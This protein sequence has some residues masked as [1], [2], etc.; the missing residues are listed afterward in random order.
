M[1]AFAG[2]RQPRA[3]PQP[4][5]VGQ[6]SRASTHLLVGRGRTSELCSGCSPKRARISGAT[7]MLLFKQFL[8]IKSCISCFGLSYPANVFARL[9]VKGISRAAR[10]R[11][12]IAFFSSH[13]SNVPGHVRYRPQRLFRSSR[14][15]GSISSTTPMRMFSAGSGSVSSD[16]L[17]P[18]SGYH[19]Q[20]A[21][22]SALAHRSAGTRRRGLPRF[23]YVSPPAASIVKACIRR[24]TFDYSAS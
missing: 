15:F 6:E 19:S 24:P 4:T 16:D 22:L 23:P 7:T 14:I 11:R 18:A 8:F 21:A 10:R 2:I 13:P 20:V 5:G 17:L 12:M 9:F 3:F 1:S